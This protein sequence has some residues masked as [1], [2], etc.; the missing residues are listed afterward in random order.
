MKVVNDSNNDYKINL[1]FNDEAFL[2]SRLSYGI[3]S[4]ANPTY[5]PYNNA[6]DLPSYWKYRNR[7]Y[8]NLQMIIANQIL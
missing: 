5:V 8:S 6:P 3:P 2:S 1:Y 7:G 4:Q